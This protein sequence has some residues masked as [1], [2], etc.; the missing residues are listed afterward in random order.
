MS[1]KEILITVA[2]VTVAVFVG[3]LLSNKVESPLSG[4]A[5]TPLAETLVGSSSNAVS[6]PRAIAF[7]NATTTQST[8]TFAAGAQNGFLNGGFEVDQHLNTGGIQ[9]VRLDILAVGGTATSTFSIRQQVSHDGDN[10]FN[11]H[12]SSTPSNLTGYATDTPIQIL[13]PAGLVFD[14]GIATSSFSFI[15]DTMGA[16]HTRFLFLADD[17]LTDAADGVQAWVQATKLQVR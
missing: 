10:W 5:V 8:N 15:F 2:L 17:L 14:P 3:S 9:A 11:L 6:I 13:T 16:Q 7:D 1:I 12:A 4:V